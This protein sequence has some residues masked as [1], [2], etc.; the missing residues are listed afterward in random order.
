MENAGNDA[1]GE[2]IE[3]QT[4]GLL[5]SDNPYRKGSSGYESWKLGWQQGYKD[6][7]YWV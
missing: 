1:W 7:I 2:G 6:L 4:N 3:A 5:I